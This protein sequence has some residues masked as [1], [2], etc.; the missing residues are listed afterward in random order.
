MPVELHNYTNP[1]SAPVLP[2]DENTIT[3]LHQQILTLFPHEEIFNPYTS[4]LYTS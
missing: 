4:F 1:Y 3:Q 2:I